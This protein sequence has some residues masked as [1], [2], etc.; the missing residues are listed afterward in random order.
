[1]LKKVPF[2]VPTAAQCNYVALFSVYSPVS[3]EH[4]L[5]RMHKCKAREMCSQAVQCKTLSNTAHLKIEHFSVSKCSRC[6]LETVCWEMRNTP[7]LKKKKIQIFA[8]CN[9]AKG[10]LNQHRNIE[11]QVFYIPKFC[12]LTLLECECEWLN[13]QALLPLPL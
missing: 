4:T 5:F 7:K 3:T 8:G 11:Y 2:G 6:L 1:M 13:T 10:L 12:L 9:W